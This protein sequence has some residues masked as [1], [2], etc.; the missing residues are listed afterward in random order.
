MNEDYLWDKTGEN[1]EI[2]RLENQLQAFR[3]R[4][5]AVPV[6]PA[7]IIPVQREIRRK[8]YR[9]IYAVAAC[10]AVAMI[11][12]SLWMGL[13]INQ[14]TLQIDLAEITLPSIM[15]PNPNDLIAPKSPVEQSEKIAISKQSPK[16]EIF[17][18]KK[19]VS[20]IAPQNKM[21]ANNRKG[22]KQTVVT[23]TEEEKFAYDQLMLAL[24][25]TSSKLKMVKDKAAGLEEPQT[26]YENQR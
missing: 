12:L 18:I 24:S 6:L 26:V 13:S 5:T 21:V 19:T 17:K 10:A 2:E 11:S 15:V 7:R 22:A 4:E 23:L 1:A 9:S 25:I 8:N 20:A 16:Q 3:Y 14:T